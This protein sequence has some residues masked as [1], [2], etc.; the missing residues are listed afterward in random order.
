MDHRLRD[1]IK[2]IAKEAHQEGSLVGL[3]SLLEE[4]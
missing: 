4:H 3:Y 1:R 2:F